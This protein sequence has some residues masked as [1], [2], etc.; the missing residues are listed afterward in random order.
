[1]SGVVGQSKGHVSGRVG[2]HPFLTPAFEVY[3][4]SI[5]SIFANNT[6]T[7]IIHFDT[8]QQDT[9]GMWSTSSDQ[10]TVPVG[11]AGIYQIT[12]QVNSHSVDSDEMST[13]MFVIDGHT[14]NYTQNLPGHWQRDAHQTNDTFVTQD[15]CEIALT[16]GQTVEFY[17]KQASGGTV[18]MDRD[19]VRV[20]AFRICGLNQ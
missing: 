17:W 5:G 13:F 9:H 8:V 1:M 2:H 11:H 16:D 12:L 14:A 10:M 15:M 3:A 18:G 4:S 20:S 19:Y 7:K 6:N